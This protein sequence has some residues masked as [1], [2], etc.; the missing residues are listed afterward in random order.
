MYETLY[1]QILKPLC[2]ISVYL[3]DEEISTGSGFAISNDGIVFTAAHVVTGR[4]PIRESDYKDPNAKIFVKFPYMPAIE[5]S[6]G[7]CGLNIKTSSFEEDLQ[8]DQAIIIP[9]TPL[10]LPFE[11]FTIGSPPTLGEEIFFAG[12]SDELQAPLGIDRLIK[13]DTVDLEFG[14]GVRQ[15]HNSDITGPIIKRGVVGNLLRMET[16]AEATNQKLQC[17]I[18]YIDNGIHSGA[19]GGPIVNHQGQAVG[20]IVQRATTSASQSLDAELAVPSGA[21]VG[22]SCLHTIPIMYQQLAAL[23]APSR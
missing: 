10:Q 18:F 22:L 23:L 9:K 11:T 4:M 8:I 19:S 1:K 20:V 13:P 17:A 6:V 7:I 14:V 12:Y 21:T 15:G 5:Y 3:D 2:S 16:I